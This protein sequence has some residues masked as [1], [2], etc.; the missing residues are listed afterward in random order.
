MIYDICLCANKCIHFAFAFIQTI[1]NYTRL[2]S[3]S[4]YSYIQ[5]EDPFKSP[6]ML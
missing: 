3:W 2:V 1:S 6:D 5:H 4:Y